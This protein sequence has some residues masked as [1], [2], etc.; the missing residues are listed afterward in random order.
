MGDFEAIYY[1]LLLQFLFVLR[2]R[3]KFKT[4][5]Q[6]VKKL[7][8]M[9]WHSRHVKDKFERLENGGKIAKMFL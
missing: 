2:S 6:R 5:I 8:E 1:F 4:K 9:V 3:N 7:S